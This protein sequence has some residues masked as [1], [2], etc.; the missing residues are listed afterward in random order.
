MVGGRPAEFAYVMDMEC[1][2]KR[3][4]GWHHDLWPEHWDDGDAIS[5][6]EG[7]SKNSWGGGESR[8]SVLDPSVRCYWRSKWNVKQ[9]TVDTNL[10]FRREDWAEN[11]KCESSVHETGCN[12]QRI[13]LR[14]KRG[15]VQALRPGPQLVWK[16]RTNQVNKLENNGD[17]GVREAR[18]V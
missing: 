6:D 12:K 2:R 16:M 7:D 4:Q 13:E 15:G 18:N 3:S 17:C 8:G 1:K 10:E 11:T 9:S 14:Q 5:E